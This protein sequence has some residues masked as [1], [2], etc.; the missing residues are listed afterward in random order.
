MDI[1]RAAS[2]PPEITR[3]VA[4]PTLSR[5]FGKDLGNL[6]NM[7]GMNDKQPLGKK[8]SQY[9]SDAFAYRE[10][11]NS[12][13]EKIHRDSVIVVDVKVNRSVSLACDIIS[14]SL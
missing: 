5:K 14:D 11:N 1:K 6:S 13:R 4:T 9:F 2:T 3:E 10:S 12:A 7:N 8:R